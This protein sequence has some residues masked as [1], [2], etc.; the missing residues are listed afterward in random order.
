M[1]K[2]KMKRRRSVPHKGDDLYRMIYR[3]VDSG[4]RDALRNHPDYLGDRAIPRTVQESIAKRVTG[5]LYSRELA[6]TPPPK[7]PPAHRL[8]QHKRT[9]L[10]GAVSVSTD[11]S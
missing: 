8:P 7:Q 1:R 3:L 5:L 4:V 9:G 10:S 6:L 11:G 2:P